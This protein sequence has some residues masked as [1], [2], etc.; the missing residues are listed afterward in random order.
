MTTTILKNARLIDGN[1]GDP[2]ADAVVVITDGKIAYAGASSGAPQ[3]DD[4]AVTIDVGGNTVCPGFFDCH[5]HLSLPGPPGSPIMEALVAPS[6]RFFELI[7]RMKATV[8]AGVTTVRDLMGVDVGVRDAVAHGL[9]EGPR[10]LVA[11]KMLSQTGGHADFHIPAGV[12]ATEII[13]G[14]LV[15]SVDQ[16]RLEARKLLRE[17]VDVI[18]IASSGGVSSP[19]DQPT[20]LGFRTEMVAAVV[21]EGQNYGG[22]PVAAHAIGL[23]GIQAAVQGGVHS[24]EHGYALT[25]ELRTEMVQRGQ[26]LVPTLIETL[27]PDTATPQAVAKSGKWHAMAQESIQASAEAGI[28]IAVGTDA[29]LVPAH[30][31]TLGELGCLVK[32]AKMTPMQAIVAGTKT[33]AEL[34]GVDDKLGTLEVGK[35]GDVVVVKGDPTTDIDSLAD[36]DNILLVLKEGKAMS[37]RGQYAGV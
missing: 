34:C 1:G 21:E 33:S 26:F 28:K 17:G 14:V 4:K 11:D 24:V 2:V 6:Y 20:F 5:T 22:R 32:F 27:H 31:A 8:E 30:G 36:H 3:A 29:G 9:V 37:N 7:G 15:D 18:K 16:A 10:L 12:S 23:A 25:D 35:L 19:N 13:G